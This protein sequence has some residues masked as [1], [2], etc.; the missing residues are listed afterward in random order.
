MDLGDRD[1]GLIEDLVVHVDC[2]AMRVLGS[3]K[4]ELLLIM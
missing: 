1:F 2:L 3:M 4:C